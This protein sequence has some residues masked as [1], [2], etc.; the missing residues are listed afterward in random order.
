M[1][2]PLAAI[3]LSACLLALAACDRTPPAVPPTPIADTPA[4]AESGAVAGSE[5]DV[6]VPSA[7]SVFPSESVTPTPLAATETDGTRK[8]ALEPEA[9][10]I[11]KPM[12]GQ[13]ND[14]SAPLSSGQ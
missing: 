12:P 1:N 11:L 4:P 14:H 3:A 9:V 10:P 13:N 2:K 5:I 7:A 6:P 8:P